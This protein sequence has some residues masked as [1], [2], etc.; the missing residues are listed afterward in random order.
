MPQTVFRSQHRHQFGVVDISQLPNKFNGHL[1][2]P[3]DTPR[4]CNFIDLLISWVSLF[5]EPYLFDI[6]NIV[7]FENTTPISQNKKVKIKKRI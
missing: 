6:H 3:L 2:T 5:T 1:A 4:I 7:P